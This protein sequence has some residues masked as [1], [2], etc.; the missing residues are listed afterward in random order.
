MLNHPVVNH[1]SAEDCEV[2]GRERGSWGPDGGNMSGKGTNNKKN[3]KRHPP[4][5]PL[6][7]SVCST[8]TGLSVFTSSMDRNLCFGWRTWYR[9][10]REQAMLVAREAKEWHR[11]SHEQAPFRTTE[12]DGAKD[13]RTDNSV[14]L[15]FVQ[16]LIGKSRML[17]ENG[18]L[19]VLIS[20]GIDLTF[21]TD[22]VEEEMDVPQQPRKL[23]QQR[24]M[25]GGT[26]A[27]ERLQQGAREEK[28][29]EF[30]NVG[31]IMGNLCRSQLKV[32]SEYAKNFPLRFPGVVVNI[33]KNLGRVPEGYIPF[34]KKW[35]R[36]IYTGGR[37]K[38]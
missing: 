36:Y 21:Q 2:G 5:K 18:H 11:G 3:K 34:V 4:I 17:E 6:E 13:K 32:A 19:P 29:L 24:E 28:G 25:Q 12:A 15:E 9:I 8:C 20:N 37:P 26:T 22:G 10:S 23:K 33:V 14:R 16:V 31:E 30:E 35:H 7:N 27:E 1:R 38:E